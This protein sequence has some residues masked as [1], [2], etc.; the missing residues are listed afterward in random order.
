[1]K[2]LFF[3]LAIIFCLFQVPLQA[4]RFYLG[5][6]T[7]MSSASFSGDGF[8]VSKFRTSYQAGMFMGVVFG[9]SEWFAIQPEMLYDRRGSKRLGVINNNTV[10]E[11]RSDF[12]T[13]PIAAKFR[14][15]VNEKFFPHFTMGP[16]WSA[17]VGQSIG[18]RTDIPLQDSE[19]IE[20]RKV[21]FGAFAGAGVDFQFNPIFITVDMRYFF[22]GINQNASENIITIRNS[23]ITLNVGLGFIF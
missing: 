7:G 22:G 8:D 9:E 18:S 11:I 10:Q 20:V 3:S 1:M 13:M 14:V 21:D 5:A 15:P 23:Q 17:R 6:K 12:F 2:R 4:Q 19:R 16:Y